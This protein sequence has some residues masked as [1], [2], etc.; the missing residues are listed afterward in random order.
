M[1]PVVPI[2]VQSNTGTIIKPTHGKSSEG[3][4][5]ISFCEHANTILNRVVLPAIRNI[6]IGHD[7]AVN[8]LLSILLHLV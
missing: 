4:T 7:C 6:N 3:L 5:H 8:D 1:V 2:I